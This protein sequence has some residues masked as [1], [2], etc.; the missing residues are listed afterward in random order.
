MSQRDVVAG[1]AEQPAVKKPASIREF[2]PVTHDVP[3]D[4]CGGT[5]FAFFSDKMRHG[6]NLRT[7]LCKRCALAQ[8][9]PQP[10]VESLSTFYSQFYHLFH[11]RV[12]VDESY[13]AKS[14]RMAERRF[15]LVRGFLDAAAKISLLEVGPGAGEFLTRCQEQSKWETLGVEPGAESYEWCAQRGLN[16]VHERFEDFTSPRR[17]GALVSFH[18]LDHLC[19]PNA[20][21]HACHSLLDDSG[22]L[23]LEVV[24]LNRL[25]NPRSEAMQFPKLFTFTCISLSN[26]LHS[27]G[28]QPIFVDESVGSLTIVSKR[29]TDARDE[30]VAIDLAKHLADLNRKNHLYRLATWLPRFSVF[31]KIRSVLNSV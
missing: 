16:V 31:G 22:L 2:V 14:K 3:C 5:D 20:F 27:A 26:Y 4:F 18:V 7:V 17:F 12:G 25:G 19:S 8:T 29:L 9:N 13:I 24:N 28:F 6:I 1:E 15:Q 30:F 10:T 21:L 11:Q 23:F